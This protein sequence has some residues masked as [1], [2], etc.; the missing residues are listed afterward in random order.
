MVHSGKINGINLK[1]SKIWNSKWRRRGFVRFV[2]AGFMG[3][4]YYHAG[5]LD[6][7]CLHNSHYTYCMDC[8]GIGYMY[9][10]KIKKQ[11]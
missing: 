1:T 7:G 8:V 9:V 4:G 5:E 11:R 2:G 6:C 10:I 3:F